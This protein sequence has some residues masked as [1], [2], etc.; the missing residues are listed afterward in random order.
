MLAPAGHDAAQ[1][2][3][4]ITNPSNYA[5]RLHVMRSGVAIARGLASHTF[6]SCNLHALISTCTHSMSS[7]HTFKRATTTFDASI[8]RERPLDSSGPLAL[9]ALLCSTCTSCRTGRLRRH[10]PNGTGASDAC[11]DPGWH[12]IYSVCK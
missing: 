9:C 5:A 11:D 10:R 12:A 3:I 7:L 1:R 6:A 4:H 8:M 2:G